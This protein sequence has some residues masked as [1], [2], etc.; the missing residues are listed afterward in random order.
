MTTTATMNPAAIALADDPAAIKTAVRR[1]YAEIALGGGAC[2]GGD[3]ASTCCSPAAEGGAA[4]TASTCCDTGA[5]LVDYGELTADIVAAADLGLGCGLP[6]RHA[7]IQ[8]GE[9]VLDLGSG[10]GIDAFIAA[11]A[12]GPAG[13]VIGVDFTPAMIERARA[14]AESA[15]FANVAFRHGDVED[16]PV[17][18]GSVDLVLSNCV[19]NLVPDK[20]RAFAEIHRVL[21][22][23]GRFVVSDVVSFGPVPAAVRQDMALWSGCIAGAMDRDAYLDLI[24]AARFGDVA[25]VASTAYDAFRGDDHGLM[26]VTIRG[27]KP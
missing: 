16:L 10:A 22:P 4:T 5:T 3:G 12:V 21:R 24:R 27:V 23:G 15:G 19:L 26:S 25:V 6:T 9:T 1:R 7:D 18:A 8:P 11:R 20:A 13:R 2:C 14:N 17:D